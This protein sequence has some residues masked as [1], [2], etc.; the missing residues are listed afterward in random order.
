MYGCA[1]WLDS[2]VAARAVEW[3][4]DRLPRGVYLN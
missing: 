3:L 4:E 1:M 2:V